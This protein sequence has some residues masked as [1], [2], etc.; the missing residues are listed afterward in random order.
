MTASRRPEREDRPVVTESI[1]LPKTLA[2]VL[3]EDLFQASVYALRPDCA[4][5]LGLSRDETR[6]VEDVVKKYVR[7]LG[8]LEGRNAVLRSNQSGD[9]FSIDASAE[10]EQ[11]RS[12]FNADIAGVIGDG[13]K[14]S[15]VSTAL[16]NSAALSGFGAFPREIYVTD[17]VTG[18][19]TLTRVEVVTNLSRDPQRPLVRKT[20]M[21]AD[22]EFVRD[23]YPFL[24]YGK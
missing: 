15:V 20:A 6:G 18:G 9:Y 21:P 7:L 5:L 2:A 16:A 13:E 10:S 19:R 3:L 12:R 4:S 17:N 24:K 14:A 22:S 23:R 1:V 11:L 8:E